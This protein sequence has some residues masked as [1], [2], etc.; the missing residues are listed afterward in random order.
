MDEDVR[1]ERDHLVFT[2]TPTSATDIA[3]NH[4]QAA[5]TDEDAKALSPNLVELSEKHA[6]VVE[7][8]ELVG[9]IDVFDEVEIGWRRDDKVHGLIGQGAHFTRVAKDDAM[10]R[11]EGVL[12][13][14][15]AVD[16]ELVRDGRLAAIDVTDPEL[17]GLTHLPSGRAV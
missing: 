11:F 13:E 3:H 2:E 5:S 10:C 6:V 7:V 12:G 14:E 4:A 1:V 16:L 9:A 17:G 8:P 15:L